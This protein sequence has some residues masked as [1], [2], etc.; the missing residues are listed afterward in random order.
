MAS[1]ISKKISSIVGLV[2]M[3][4]VAVGC[5][6]IGYLPHKFA[7]YNIMSEANTVEFTATVQRVEVKGE[8]VHVYIDGYD[9]Y[10]I[11]KV[12]DSKLRKKIMA[13]ETNEQ[14]YY[15][16]AWWYYEKHPDFRQSDETICVN[17]VTLRTRNEDM[18]SFD[19]HNRMKKSGEMNVKGI[20]FSLAAAALIG[21]CSC[22][23]T[24]CKK[25]RKSEIKSEPMSET[26][27]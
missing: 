27:K 3:L 6:F 5:V 26:T 8:S 9:W 21:A 4:L 24:L 11:A 20:S 18:L 16:I 22:V 2:L 10:L 1:R 19:E 13:L 15:R 14:V 12:K 23:W 7:D 17:F 25:D